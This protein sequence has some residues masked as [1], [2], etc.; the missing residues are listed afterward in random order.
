VLHTPALTELPTDGVAGAAAA[1]PARPIDAAPIMMAV[2]AVRAVAVSF[3][4]DVLLFMGAGCACEHRIGARSPR[5]LKGFLA[6]LIAAV[7]A[8]CR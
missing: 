3:D 2:I 1:A 5:I 4:I 7:T 8:F 6:A